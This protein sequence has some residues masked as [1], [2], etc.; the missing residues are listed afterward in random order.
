MRGDGSIHSCSHPLSLRRLLCARLWLG[1]WGWNVRPLSSVGL[2]SLRAGLHPAQR[3]LFLAAAEFAQHA[4]EHEGRG[5]GQR[6]W[7]PA[8]LGEPS[9]GVGTETVPKSVPGGGRA[10]QRRTGGCV[11]WG[12][13]RG[14]RRPGWRGSG[15]R[16]ASEREP[17]RP[18]TCQARLLSILAEDSWAR[19]L[20]GLGSPVR[21]SCSSM[22]NGLAGRRLL[23]TISLTA[24]KRKVVRFCSEAGA[25]GAARE[26]RDLRTSQAWSLAVGHGSRFPAQGPGRVVVSLLRQ[27]QLFRVF[28]NF[29]W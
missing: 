18:Y 3:S 27:E 11:T 13:T 8:G 21:S 22:E 16:P 23:P 14:S 2:P 24:E 29:F 10:T 6:G 19:N 26:Q 7:P 9:G 15:P 5:R 28:F 4:E 20:T 12:G 17:G 1:Q 25:A